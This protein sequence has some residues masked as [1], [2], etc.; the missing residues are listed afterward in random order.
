[1]MTPS[2][3]S[4]EKDTQDIPVTKISNGVANGGGQTLHLFPN[5]A[6]VSLRLGEEGWNSTPES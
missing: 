1:M 4:G 6:G 5:G 2:R 3:V